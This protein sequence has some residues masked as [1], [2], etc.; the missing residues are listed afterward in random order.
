MV[1]NHR[2]NGTDAY[3]ISGHDLLKAPQSSLTSAS[4]GSLSTGGVGDL[5]T[6]DATILT[7]LITRVG[8]LETKLQ[9]LGLL[10]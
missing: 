6:A 1:E 4:G 2:H 8:E 10:K 5:K 9:N 7:N 3:Q